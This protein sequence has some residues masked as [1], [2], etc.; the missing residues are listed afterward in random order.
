MKKILLSAL[1]LTMVALLLFAATV[2][3]TACGGIEG[4]YVAEN[5]AELKLKD[6]KWSMSREGRTLTGPYEKDGDE[7]SFQ[8]EVEGETGTLFTG[9][10]EGKILT[11]EDVEFKKK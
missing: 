7:I 8:V 3:L 9:T 11:I 6:G 2:S 4:T 1:S 10:L 5:G